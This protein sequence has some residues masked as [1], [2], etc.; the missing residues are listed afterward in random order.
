MI[1]QLESKEVEDYIKNNPKTVLLDV[2]TEEEWDSDFSDFTP[3]L[4]RYADSFLIIP[5]EGIDGINIDMKP[6]ESGDYSVEVYIVDYFNNYSNALEFPVYV[7]DDFA[8]ISE[9]PDL[10]I[11][12]N[13]NNIQIFW[14]HSLQLEDNIPYLQWNESVKGVWENIPFE[15][16][17]TFETDDGCLYFLYQERV[18]NEQN[19]FFRLIYE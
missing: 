15:E 4:V 17:S 13:S 18:G 1:K 16:L 6:V 19:K 9:L 3:W 2:R 12:I 14:P 5:D 7:P 11:T 8:D 10:N